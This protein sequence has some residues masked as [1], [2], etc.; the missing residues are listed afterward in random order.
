MR[1][2]TTQ[3]ISSNLELTPEGF[4]LC[5]NVPIARTGTQLYLESELLNNDGQPLVRGNADG[6]VRIER[7]PGVVFD[8]ATIAS[9]E[10]KPVTLD[11]PTSDVNPSNWSALAKGVVQ[12]VRRGVSLEDDYLVADLLI[13]SADAIKQVRDKGLREVSC[14]YDSGYEE[15]EPGRGRQTNIVGNHLA[16]VEKG[17]C[18]SRCAIGDSMQ[19]NK[20]TFMDR[21]RAAFKNRDEAELEE[22]LKESTSDEEAETEEEKKKREAKEAEDRK[23]AD[24]LAALLTRVTDL[25]VKLKDR[26]SNDDEANET[27]EEKKAREEK[28]AKEKEGKSND[29]AALLAE[30][31]DVRSRVEILS[32]GFA[33]PT[34]DAAG[35]AKT[36]RDSHCAMKRAALAAAYASPKT[37]DAVAPLLANVDL[38][39]LSCDALHSTFVGASEIVRHTNNSQSKGTTDGVQ[40]PV[41]AADSIAAMN[42]KN[43]EFWKQQ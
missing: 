7:D 3:I 5:R 20:V 21:V 26:K 4:L 33:V 40:A 15:I 32:P 19:K 14:G 24:A 38:Q 22:A 39:K 30:A 31:Q 23:T 43:A 41:R 6:I 37:R 13:T 2:Y 25:E 8:E 42:R 34:H 10:G 29:S 9:F 12:N 35:D 36:V 28:E 11:H 16:L 27:E 1:F 18:G 17:R